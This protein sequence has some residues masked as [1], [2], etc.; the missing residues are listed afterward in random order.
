MPLQRS[1][2]LAITLISL[3]VYPFS[4]VSQNSVVTDAPTSTPQLPKP[5]RTM[6]LAAEAPDSNLTAPVLAHGYFVQF[7]RH[8]DSIGQA[9]LFISDVN[10]SARYEISASPPNASRVTILSVDIGKQGRPVFAGRAQLASGDTVG[11]IG[12]STVTGSSL[13]TVSTGTYLPTAVSVS[14]DGSLWTIG[15]EY[16][17]VSE[18]TRRWNNYDTLRHFTPSGVLIEHYLPRWNSNV[19]YV[20]GSF[21]NGLVAWQAYTSTGEAI[22]SPSPSDSFPVAGYSKASD[23]YSQI[24]LKSMGQVLTLYDGINNSL[25]QVDQTRHVVTRYTLATHF[26]QEVI[27]GFALTSDG[28]LYASVVSNFNLR[29]VLSG[30]FELDLDNSTHMAQWQE[31]SRSVTTGRKQGEPARLLGADGEDITYQTWQPPGSPRSI[32]WLHRSPN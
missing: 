32:S 11:F 14:D 2:I 22:D 21:S 1:V 8:I 10:G 27:N 18:S 25:Y 4:A 6:T 5:Y 31:F 17:Q 7:K 24:F 13:Q 12:S 26:P 15:A 30:L 9:N 19:A 20:T 23:K 3:S 16:Y 28:H 29:P